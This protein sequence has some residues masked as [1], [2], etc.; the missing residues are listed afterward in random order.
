MNELQN[1]FILQSAADLNRISEK[2]QDDSDEKS[3]ETLLREVFRTLHTIKGTAQTFG[4]PVSAHL[5][6]ALENLL[7]AAKGNLISAADLK[8]LLPEGIGILA[9]S[10][11]EKNFQIPGSFAKKIQNFQI[12][13]Q[14]TNSKNHYLPEIPE[15]FSAS[16]S[17]RE[18][19]LLNDVLED[20]SNLYILE[21]DFDAAN[22]ADEFKDFRRRL[23]E[24][25][26][27]VA[28][29]PGAKLAAQ[30]KIGFR[31]IFAY[32]ENIEDIIENTSAEIVFEI[33][34]ANLN[35]LRGII[36]QAAGHGRTLARNLG[37]K[38][39]FEI[40]V[41]AETP[42]SQILKLIF[43]ALLHLV[44]N[45]VSHAIEEKGKI[46]I[47]IKTADKGL[48]LSVSDNGKG[49][50]AEKI[51]AKAIEKNL[52]PEN[53]VLSEGE[54]AD[55]IFAP[56]FSTAAAVTE[57]SG[58]GVGLDAVKNS[59]ENAGG[60]I[61]VKSKSGKGATFEIF[62]PQNFESQKLG[63]AETNDGSDKI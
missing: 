18:K 35:N 46:V 40:F 28:T 27:I 16:L 2:L 9:K 37:K 33:F 43:D 23:S 45:A 29:L 34:T 12:E 48:L 17:A 24:K 63:N 53:K 54:I 55:L 4:F 15:E 20:G 42:S 3:F 30:N 51:H 38:I 14:T 60:L 32:G 7:S 36:T 1:E 25:G 61:S 58:R 21:I 11:G 26:E 56:G 59:I 41:E 13:L 44:R 62:L 47:M 50:D 8:S 57:I 22:F 31:I 6:H 52:V 49:L 19:S 10:L 5:A 39:D